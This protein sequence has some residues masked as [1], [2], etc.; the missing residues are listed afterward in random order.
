M[1]FAYNKEQVGDVLM[2]I[3]E[4]KKDIKRQVERKGRVARVFAEETGQTLAW[5][6]FEASA[7]IAVEGNGQVFLSEEE[8]AILNAELA[9]EGFTERLE[10]SP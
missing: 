1:I 6:I 9:Q 2:V 7:L 10:A 8:L 5:N 4:D 3:L